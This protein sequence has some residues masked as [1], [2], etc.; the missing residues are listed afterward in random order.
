MVRKI[1]FA[2]T[3]AAVAALHVTAASA[4]SRDYCVAKLPFPPV[5]PSKESKLV[6]YQAYAVPMVGAN[7]TVFT[8]HAQLQNQSSGTITV[9]VNVANLSAPPAGRWTAGSQTFPLTSY[10]P[11]DVIIAKLTVPGKTNTIPV[12]AWNVVDSLVRQCPFSR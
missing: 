10:Q 4:Q 3:L 1:A 6:V 7:S 8:Y 5:P 2:A 11:K 12:D 9:S